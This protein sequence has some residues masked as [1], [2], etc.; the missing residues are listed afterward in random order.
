MAAMNRR[1]LCLS[2]GAF[3]A[4]GLLAEAQ[5]PGGPADTTDMAKSRV[6]RFDQMKVDQHA[7]GGWGRQVM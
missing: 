6:F 5:T 3:A 2:A 1:D 7:N 4:L